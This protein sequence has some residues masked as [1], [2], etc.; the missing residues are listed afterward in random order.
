MNGQEYSQLIPK[1]LHPF[2]PLMKPFWRRILFHHEVGL[3]SP[4][5]CG[6]DAR[7]YGLPAF[8]IKFQAFK[9]LWH[10]LEQALDLRGALLAHKALFRARKIAFYLTLHLP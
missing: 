3:P 10:T 2:P 8:A 9:F 6:P 1:I 4:R 7:G 5:E